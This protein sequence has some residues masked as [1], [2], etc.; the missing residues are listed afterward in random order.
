MFGGTEE[1][2]AFGELFSIGAIGG[3]KNKAVSMSWYCLMGSLQPSGRVTD[4]NEGMQIS[5]LV[6]DIVSSKLGVPS[7][8][9][10]LMVRCCQLKAS[11]MCCDPNIMFSI[12]REEVCAKR[13]TVALDVARCLVCCTQFHDMKGADVGWKGSTF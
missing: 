9:C 13:E 5:K 12:K 10:Y 6:S 7:N 11:E 8:R 4:G 1:P 2:C 3:E